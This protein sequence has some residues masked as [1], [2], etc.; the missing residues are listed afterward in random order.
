[1]VGSDGEH[2]CF[3]PKQDLIQCESDMS[4][5]E[6]VPYTPVFLSCQWGVI[7]SAYEISIKDH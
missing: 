5:F 6:W 2:W 4:D 7:Y 1:M 3:G